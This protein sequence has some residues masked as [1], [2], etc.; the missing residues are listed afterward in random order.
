M[1]NLNSRVIIEYL[2][3]KRNIKNYKHKSSNESLQAVKRQ[4]KNKERIDTIRKELK[5][6]SYKLS[7]SELKEIKKNLYNIERRN[8]FELRKTKRYLDKL[9]KKIL[10][11]DKYHYHD[12]FEYRGIKNIQ[13]YQLIKIIINQY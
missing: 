10:K 8:Q 4:S 5:E 11:L 12:D 13:N 6:S 2:S 7:R 3:R 1:E 9:D